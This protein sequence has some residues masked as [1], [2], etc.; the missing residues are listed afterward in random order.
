MKRQFPSEDL[1][2]NLVKGRVA[3]AS[4]SWASAAA[5]GFKV[6]PAPFTGTGVVGL[7]EGAVT[8]GAAAEVDE[9][10]AGADETAS[11]EDSAAPLVTVTVTIETWGAAQ[12]VAVAAAEEATALSLA[13]VE[14][15]TALSLAIVEEATP[16]AVA[17]ELA[18]GGAAAAPPT[19]KV[20]VA[21]APHGAWSITLP[22]TVKQVPGALRGSRVKVVAPGVNLNNWELVTFPPPSARPP[23]EN[24]MTVF[25]AARRE[26]KFMH[27]WVEPLTT[28]V[29]PAWSLWTP[30]V[31]KSHFWAALPS[32]AATWIG[33]KLARK[34]PE[35][36]STKRHFPSDVLI[37]VDVRARVAVL[38]RFWASAVASLFSSFTTRASR[39]F[40]GSAAVRLAP[41]KMVDSEKI[42]VEAN[43]DWS[44]ALE[45]PL[46]NE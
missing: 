20:W 6:P 36:G 46:D 34:S 16:L 39:W 35:R 12:S 1:I 19:E 42:I 23:Q 7:A 17:E 14:E 30:L 37:S 2:W 32:Q 29:V 45:R 22:L 18:A 27:A 31:M 40:K 11:D 44:K 28:K 24:M 15:A 26:S 41:S 43:E 13:T 25:P 8:T 10:R 21:P 33:V 9:T 3:V 4:N 5:A 38:S